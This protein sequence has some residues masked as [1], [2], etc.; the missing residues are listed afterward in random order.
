MAATQ[1]SAV[2]TFRDKTAPAGCLWLVPERPPLSHLSP[3]H[4]LRPGGHRL[5]RARAAAFPPAR[6]EPGR[7]GLPP[8][9]ASAY[10]GVAQLPPVSCRPAA[11]PGP[12][13]PASTREGRSWGEGPERGFL[14]RIHHWGKDFSA[15][16]QQLGWKTGHRRMGLDRRSKCLECRASPKGGQDREE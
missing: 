2:R 13:H 14:P 16:P 5:R 12:P 3:Q 15:E 8:E 6:E 11:G 4:G 7:S 1:G 9:P 10:L